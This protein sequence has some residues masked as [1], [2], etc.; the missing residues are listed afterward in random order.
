MIKV[1]YEAGDLWNTRNGWQFNY[2]W[3]DHGELKLLKTL[4]DV[5]ITRRVKK[6]LGLTGVR[7]YKLWDSGDGLAFRIKG[8]CV[9]F[10][11]RI[12]T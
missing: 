5:Q 6:A 9:G 12:E 8:T 7:S 11:W 2:S 1:C 4:S 3:R 10:N